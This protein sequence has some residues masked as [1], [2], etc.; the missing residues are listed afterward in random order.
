MDTK[1][2]GN[3]TISNGRVYIF[4][5]FYPRKDPSFGPGWYVFGRN[6]VKYG[7]NTDTGKGNYIK[8]V[9]RPDTPSRK[10]KHYNCKVA[11]GWKTKRDAQAVADQ[12]NREHAPIEAIKD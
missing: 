7:V 9:A 1:F 12:L 3:T 4:V 11:R 8:L 10:H 2:E 6:S 5:D